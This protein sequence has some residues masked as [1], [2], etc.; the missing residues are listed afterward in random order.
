MQSINVVQLI[1]EVVIFTCF[2]VHN[3]SLLESRLVESRLYLEGNKE[4]HLLVFSLYVAHLVPGL[5]PFKVSST[6]ISPRPNVRFILLW[7]SW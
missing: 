2:L 5:V 7:L 1:S 6:S 3:H 4:S